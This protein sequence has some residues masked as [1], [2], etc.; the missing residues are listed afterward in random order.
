MKKCFQN[1]E[2]Y[3][4]PKSKFNIFMDGHFSRFYVFG[5]TWIFCYIYLL[6]FQSK[7]SF[8]DQIR[9]IINYIRS[10]AG[11]GKNKFRYRHPTTLQIYYAIFCTRENFFLKAIL[12]TAWMWGTY[13]LILQCF[14]FFALF[15]IS[16]ELRWPENTY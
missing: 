1:T 15:M 4:F 7:T 6:L 8:F 13:N 16:E 10:A 14:P 3:F 2:K 12:I 11:T 5:I 9:S